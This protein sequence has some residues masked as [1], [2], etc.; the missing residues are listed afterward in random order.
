MTF[1]S[2]EYISTSKITGFLIRINNVHIAFGNLS[3][4]NW[5]NCKATPR[6]S[7]STL[8]GIQHSMHCTKCSIIFIYFSDT[9]SVDN[10]VVDSPVP[11]TVDT[12]EVSMTFTADSSKD[13]T[14]NSSLKT[15]SSVIGSQENSFGH[16]NPLFSNVNGDTPRSHLING[17]QA[18]EI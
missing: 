9:D 7:F 1:L 2:I 4:G 15:I 14:H 18:S 11:Q 12:Q 8:I 16:R 17:L 5:D 6:S 3:T 10:N 13:Y